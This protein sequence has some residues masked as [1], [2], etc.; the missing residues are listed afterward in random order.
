[1]AWI[2]K[3]SIQDPPFWIHG[4]AMKLFK[5]FHWTLNNFMLKKLHIFLYFWLIFIYHFAL[6]FH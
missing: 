5:I 6:N 2:H 4:F 3:K 1:M